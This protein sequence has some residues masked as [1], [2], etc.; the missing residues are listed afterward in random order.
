MRAWGLIHQYGWEK[1]A[2]NTVVHSKFGYS[3]NLADG[4]KAGTNTVLRSYVKQAKPA[5]QAANEG[6]AGFWKVI[7]MDSQCP[8]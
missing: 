3:R 6:T 4:S 2:D 8:K 1:G 5:L 7:H